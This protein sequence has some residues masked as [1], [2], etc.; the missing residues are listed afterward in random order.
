MTF[1]QNSTLSDTQALTSTGF[2]YQFPASFANSSVHK[3]LVTVS[4]P[5]SLVGGAFVIKEQF[6]NSGT[7]VGVP[8]RVSVQATGGGT[9]NVVNGNTATAT[10]V[11]GGASINTTGITTVTNTLT[12]VF[13]VA[14]ATGQLRLEATATSGTANV[15]IEYL[16]LGDD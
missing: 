14:G 1:I 2:N 3:I 13:E 15:V 10:A 16:G 4:S 6:P 5:S 7:W 11:T 9:P 12:A 8:Q